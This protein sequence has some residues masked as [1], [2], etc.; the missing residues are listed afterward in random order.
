ML[1]SLE[2]VT[3]EVNRVQTE[4]IGGFKGL[5]VR[6]II[7]RPGAANFNAAVMSRT[8]LPATTEDEPKDVRLAYYLEVDV[9][10]I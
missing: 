5:Y 9:Y 2:S 7:Y 3:T 6:T 1:K 10:Q 4:V 8:P